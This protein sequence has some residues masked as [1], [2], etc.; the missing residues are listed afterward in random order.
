[1]AGNNSTIKN[2]GSTILQ[3]GITSSSD[4]YGLFKY[5]AKNQEESGPKI[6]DEL[7]FLRQ[8]AAIKARN[9]QENAYLR[10]DYL[11]GDDMAVMQAKSFTFTQSTNFSSDIEGD[12]FSLKQSCI[13]LNVVPIQ[14]EEARKMAQK[15]AE[16]KAM[17]DASSSVKEQF[18]SSDMASSF[19]LPINSTT[20][21]SKLYNDSAKPT[22]MPP[23]INSH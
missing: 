2:D 11:R 10:Q 14:G 4:P 12:A 1:M 19:G 5:L 8:E 13:E 17:K 7:R 6:E 20:S 18:K 21:K 3:S 16:F 22:F 15:E 23:K 9:P